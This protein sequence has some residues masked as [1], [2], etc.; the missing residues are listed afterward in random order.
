MRFGIVDS[1]I[2][3]NIKE[4]LRLFKHEAEI[5]CKYCNGGMQICEIT[6]QKTWAYRLYALRRRPAYEW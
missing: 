6:S 3:E 4:P 2:M 1:Y 5:L